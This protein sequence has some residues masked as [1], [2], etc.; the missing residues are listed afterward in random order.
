V[1]GAGNVAYVI[2]DVGAA[3]GPFQLSVIPAATVT[4]LV[5]LTY[6]PGTPNPNEDYYIT[7]NVPR[8]T[9]VDRDT[10]TLY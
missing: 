6:V 9:R 10:W 2:C 5:G 4:N 7:E 8:P 1:I 3:L